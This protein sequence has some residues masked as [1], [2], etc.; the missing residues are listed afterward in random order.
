MIVVVFREH[1]SNRNTLYYFCVREL[2]RNEIE[3]LGVLLF[4]MYM[5][6]THQTLCVFNVS[7]KMLSLAWYSNH[8]PGNCRGLA[9]GPN[10]VTTKM[11]RRWE[12]SVSWYWVIRILYH[13]YL[14]TSAWS[15]R[16]SLEIRYQLRY[17]LL[18]ARWCHREPRRVWE[19]RDSL[20]ADVRYHQT[21]CSCYILI[22]YKLKF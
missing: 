11:R 9:L 18:R 8:S 17:S 3:R 1:R 6:S 21:K 7:V 19:T 16:Y 14:S 5:R 15:Q 4:I 20:L 22:N 10:T 13:I 12:N 2:V